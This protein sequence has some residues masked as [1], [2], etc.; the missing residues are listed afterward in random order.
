[1]IYD[2][3]NDMTGESVE[4]NFSM[5]DVPSIGDTVMHEGEKLRRIA[6]CQIDAGI[7]AK[8]HGYPY[9]SSSLPR[10]LEGC[11]TNRQGK[12]IVTSRRHEHELISQ[13]GY[14]RD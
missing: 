6:C 11:D 4:L 8:I 12:P 14:V 13:H 2:F 3:V 10:N 5:A 9:V 7:D 1:M